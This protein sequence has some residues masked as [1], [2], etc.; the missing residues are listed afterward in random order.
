[1]FKPNFISAD[2]NMCLHKVR[3][4]NTAVRHIFHHSLRMRIYCKN[5]SGALSTKTNQL[6]EFRTT[7]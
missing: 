4:R 5:T 3:M 7:R 1:M 6:I 2:A